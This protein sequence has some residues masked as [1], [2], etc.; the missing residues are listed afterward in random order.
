MYRTALSESPTVT[1]EP[2]IE[3]LV[4][5]EVNPVEIWPISPI[6]NLLKILT[7]GNPLLLYKNVSP[8]KELTKPI[9]SGPTISETVLLKRKISQEK[10]EKRKLSWM[11]D[12]P[13]EVALIPTLLKCLRNKSLIKALMFSLTILLIYKMQ[14]DYCKKLCFYL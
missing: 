9:A 3:A 6:I 8:F 10:M 1:S 2:L 4:P 12:I 7:F 5:T 11:I 13:M 14:K